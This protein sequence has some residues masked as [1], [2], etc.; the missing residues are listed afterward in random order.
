[1]KRAMT[2]SEPVAAV[3]LV[4]LATACAGLLFAQERSV[5]P[6][7]L[8]SLVLPAGEVRAAVERDRA[9]AKRVPTS[10]EVAKVETL[11]RE[12]GRAQAQ[13]FEEQQSYERRQRALRVACTELA[14]SGRDAVDALRARSVER[15]EDALALRL[16]EKEVPEVLGGFALTLERGGVT[17]DGAIVGPHFVVRT[18]YKAQWNASC[19]FAPNFGMARVERLAYHGWQAFHV[20]ALSPASRLAALEEYARA[21][22]PHV[23]EARA[24]ILLGAGEPRAAVPALSAAQ[25]AE[26]SIRLRNYLLA[27]RELAKTL[28]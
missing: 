6:D 23:E 17:R 21:G 2:L 16:P 22:G 12:H 1:M 3:L 24:V 20:P 13:F 26:G 14:R 4:V 10:K 18:L 27:A 8:P 19:G 28:D 15:L 25:A 7:E 11:L 5:V 9:L